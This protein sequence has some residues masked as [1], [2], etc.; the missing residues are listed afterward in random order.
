MDTASARTTSDDQ[1]EQAAADPLAARRARTNEKF[2]KIR[3]KHPK[4]T[5]PHIKII[6]ALI[7]LAL[8]QKAV[9]EHAVANDAMVIDLKRGMAPL[10]KVL[11]KSREF[12]VSTTSAILCVIGEEIG[13][14]TDEVKALT[15]DV[16][17]AT[18]ELMVPVKSETNT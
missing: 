10:G 16:W 2:E 17:K 5:L 11:D 13:A 7:A 4:F 12:T 6:S 14:D 3:A 8:T 15:D 9:T 18:E 1:A